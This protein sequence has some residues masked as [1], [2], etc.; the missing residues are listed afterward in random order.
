VKKLRLFLLSLLCLWLCQPTW[1]AEKKSRKPQ[2]KLV[3]VYFWRYD[4]AKNREFLEPVFRRVYSNAPAR[5]V[6][7]ALFKGPTPQE[8]KRGFY[9]LDSKGLR[10]GPLSIRRSV[11]F[12]D[13]VSVRY[14]SWAGDMTADQFRV[15]VIKS[16]LQIPTIKKVEVSVDGDKDFY[17]QM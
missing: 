10:I 17:I 7:E 12:V 15:A 16:L 3:R 1:C 9:N 13:F 8:K 11:A 5:E 4:N 2:T 6:L 14:K